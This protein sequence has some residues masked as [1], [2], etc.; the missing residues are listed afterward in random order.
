MRVLLVKK[1][2]N[3]NISHG[4]VEN[5][6]KDVNIRK[7]V[8]HYGNHLRKKKMKCE[9]NGTKQKLKGRTEMPDIIVP[10]C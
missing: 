6:M 1:D 4:S 2:V 10:L 8:H 5:I 9:Q 3:S 7:H